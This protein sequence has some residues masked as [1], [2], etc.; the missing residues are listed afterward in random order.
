MIHLAKREKP[1]SSI[2]ANA[3]TLPFADESFDKIVSTDVFEHIPRAQKATGEIYRILKPGGK[4]F[5]VI[6]DPAEGRFTEVSDHL[7]R[8]EGKTDVA[9]WEN[10]FKKSNFRV[11]S[12]ASE[13]Y[14]RKDWRRIF[15][16]SFLVKLKDKPGFACAFNPV[17]RPGT[18]ILQKPTQE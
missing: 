16:L 12:E 15:N 14:R 8:S 6:A 10:L 4:A 13:K 11:L 17:H 7:K 2:Q 3:V 9:W 18:Y 1:T 5:I